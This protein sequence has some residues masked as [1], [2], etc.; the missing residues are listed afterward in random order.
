MFE[1]LLGLIKFIL[2]MTVA[3]PG[4][5]RVAGGHQSRLDQI[6]SMKYVTA[7]GEV[8]KTTSQHH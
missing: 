4:L 6:I 8:L 2:D 3:W 7:G 1:P 5:G